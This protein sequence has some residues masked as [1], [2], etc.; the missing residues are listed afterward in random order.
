M[1][2]MVVYHCYFSEKCQDFKIEVFNESDTSNIFVPNE[3]FGIYEKSNEEVN[4]RNFFIHKSQKFGI[5]WGCTDR[6]GIGYLPSKGT[7]NLIAYNFKNTKCL[8]RLLDWK[9][10]GLN[11][12]DKNWIF[13]GKSLATRSANGLLKMFIQKISVLNY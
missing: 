9:W 2:A 1:V 5:W 3:I 13:V 6:W 8:S 7:C 12:S 4:G 10:I 11:A